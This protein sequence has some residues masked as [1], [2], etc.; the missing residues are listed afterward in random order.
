MWGRGLGGEGG[1]RRKNMTRRFTNVA[2][3]LGAAL[4]LGGPAHGIVTFKQLDEN[5]FSVSHRIKGFGSRGKATDL[6]FT[7][8]ASLCAAAGFSHYQVIGQES[9]AAQPYRAA[10][11]TV[12]VKFYFEDAEE[13]ISCE[14]AAD[15]EY[16]DEIRAKLAEMGY[17]APTPP[18]PAEPSTGGSSD[19]GSLGSCAQGC[20]IEQIAAM[21]RA[22]LP[23]EKIRAA[24][25]G[26]E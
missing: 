8:V 20:T 18:Q 10:N 11:A 9:Q 6:V 21:A 1:T 2:L 3:F 19:A 26:G 25:G 7:K 17:E 15:P 23:D 22:G 14:P 4:L 12:T 5:T 16:V 24:C 13:R